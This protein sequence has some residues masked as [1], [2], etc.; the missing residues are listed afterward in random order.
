MA[1]VATPG[2][3]RRGR[4]KDPRASWTAL[5]ATQAL[6]SVG[7]VTHSAEV[8]RTVE[9]GQLTARIES[10]GARV[11]DVRVAMV[12]ERVPP[13][14]KLLRAWI[15]SGGEPY[16]S[17]FEGT[18]FGR[19]ADRP[20]TEPLREGE[21]L[22][23]EFPGRALTSLVEPEPR[24]DLLLESEK[25]TRRCVPLLLTSRGARLAW[26]TDQDFTA[27]T[28]FSIEA[29]PSRLGPVSA[30]ASWMGT[31]G[32]WLG[33][34]RVEVG[35]GIGGAGC[36][37]DSCPVDNPEDMSIDYTTV[38]PLHA[39]VHTPLWESSVTSIGIGFRYR[40]VK[41]AAD[42][43]SGRE[44]FWVHGP[45]LV[46]VIGAGAEP[47]PSTDLGGARSFFVGL[48]LPIGYA[49]SET[50]EQS[51]SVGLSLRTFFLTF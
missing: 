11:R 42:T 8:R 43:F 41:L 37:D 46:P 19:G 48:E 44:S 1:A 17:G 26:Q 12:T 5:L 22:V 51:L 14:V 25:G 39:G 23:L 40:A 6:V 20:A 49:F 10:A 7:C 4:N 29:Y 18:R 31:F 3:V 21:R 2:V 38:F 24:V 13:A 34:Y 15:A 47:I 28:D 16:C 50:G 36:P 9:V 35:A 27:G 32:V 45:V 30:L 33:E